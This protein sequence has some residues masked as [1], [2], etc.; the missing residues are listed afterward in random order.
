MHMYTYKYIDIYAYTYMYTYVC[1]YKYMHIYAYVH[2]WG[3]CTRTPM[4]NPPKWRFLLMD[5]ES[6]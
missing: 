4:C 2:W 6:T 5:V 3:V 1:M